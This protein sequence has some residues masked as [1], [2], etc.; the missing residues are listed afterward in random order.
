MVRFRY[1]LLFDCNAVLL[2]FK[3]FGM[4]GTILRQRHVA[5]IALSFTFQ[6]LAVKVC[7]CFKRA[8][9][10]PESFT[11][12]LYIF[13]NISRR[14]RRRP[15]GTQGALNL[16]PLEIVSSL[17]AESCRQVKPRLQKLHK[18]AVGYDTLAVFFPLTLLCSLKNMQSYVLSEVEFAHMVEVIAV[19]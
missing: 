12:C 18:T 19:W 1:F 2:R 14:F 16:W 10:K 9:I 13:I 8:A 11:N 7:S 4:F 6:K 17:A 3:N 15:T 5:T